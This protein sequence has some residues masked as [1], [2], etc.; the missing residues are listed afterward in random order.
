MTV[1]TRPA[2]QVDDERITTRTHPLTSH[3]QLLSTDI[4]RLLAHHLPDDA[5]CMLG[6]TLVDLYPE[7]SWNFV[8]GQASPRDRVGVY[9]FARYDPTF[10]GE[11]GAERQALLLRRSCKVLAHEMCHLFGMSHCIYF[12]CLMNGS[13]HLKESDA[14]PLH[15]CPVCLRKLHLSNQFDVI[16]RLRRLRDVWRKNDYEPEAEWL[17]RRMEYVRGNCSDK[18]T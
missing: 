16:E 14:R 8:F 9:S 2:L 7:S 4:L 18:S 13:N 5:Y 10:N 11:R 17:E 1:S 12:H 15:L 3:T 6:V